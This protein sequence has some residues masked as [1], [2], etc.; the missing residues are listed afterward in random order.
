MKALY[1]VTKMKLNRHIVIAPGSVFS[2]VD[3]TLFMTTASV[4][5]DC[6]FGSGLPQGQL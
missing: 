1:K 5:V 3:D 2:S 6:I 4:V